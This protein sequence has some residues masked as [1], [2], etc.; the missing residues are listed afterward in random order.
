MTC[1]IMPDTHLDI[2]DTQG[3]VDVLCCQCGAAGVSDELERFLND[4]AQSVL[5]VRRKI[6]HYIVAV[7][8]KE[9]IHRW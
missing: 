4:F 9:N 5:D 8:A 2:L 1:I 6:R 3:A 7:G